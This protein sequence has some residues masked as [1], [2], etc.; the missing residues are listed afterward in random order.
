MPQP[1]P[2]S[3]SR[4]GA[5]TD[6]A[7]TGGE[8]V[9]AALVIACGALAREIA[10]LRRINGW[11]ALDVQCLPPELHNHPEQIPARVRAAIIAARPRYSTIFVAYGDCGTGGQLDAVLRAEG[12]ERLPGAHCYEVFATASQFAQLCEAELGTF[13]LTDFLVR[14]FDRLVVGTLGIDIH[15]ELT[16]EYFRHYRRVVYLVQ[17]HSEPLVA[18][19]R[20]IALRL[21]LEFKVQVTGYGDL[22]G[23]L[24]AVH[25]RSRVVHK[26]HAAPIRGA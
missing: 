25:E 1:Q 16:A 21:G 6:V 3:H 23:S 22:A 13:Y 26:P 20:K 2:D 10:A 8:R 19:A 18:A 11:A 24:A 5:R 9:P 12:V 15:P 4:A 17:V 14:H 7:A